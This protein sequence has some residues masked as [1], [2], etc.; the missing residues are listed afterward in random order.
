MENNEMD[1][2]NPSIVVAG[3]IK[4]APE[5]REAL[6]KVLQA[7]V[8]RVRKKDGCIAY[9]L[10]VDV[11]EPNVVR[12]SEAWRDQPTLET[13]IAGEEFQGVQKELVHIKFIERSVQR[14]DVS[15]ATEI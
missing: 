5:D 15:S 2:A 4:V 11:V 7:H 1:K 3:Y 6:V 8:P 10:A 9:T 13:H 12:M 14:Y